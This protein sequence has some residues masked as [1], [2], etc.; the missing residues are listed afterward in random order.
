MNKLTIG[1]YTFYDIKAFMELNNIKTRATVYNWVKQEKA[2]Q[3]NIVKSAW[4][5]LA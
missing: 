2:I 3:K 5:R 4:F 1:E